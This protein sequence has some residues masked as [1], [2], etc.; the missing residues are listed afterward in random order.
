MLQCLS[1][2]SIVTQHHATCDGP[3]GI[4][5]VQGKRNGPHPR[6][7][8]WQRATRLSRLPGPG[9]AGGWE[10]RP[11]DPPF[12]PPAL[13]VAFPASLRDGS[14]QTC[15]ERNSQP[16]VQAHAFPPAPGSELHSSPQTPSLTLT[17]RA[18]SPHFL[19]RCLGHIS[20]WRSPPWL[21]LCP[22]F[23]P[24]SRGGEPFSTDLS[25]RRSLGKQPT[26]STSGEPSGHSLHACY[27]VFKS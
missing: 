8:Q 1:P 24:Q 13:S 3:E 16:P 17:P 15:P 23:P 14:N 12:S 19:L 5:R 25:H 11:W 21:H 27:S 6:R 20:P 7:Q 26:H 2:A 22:L 9:R 4:S 10:P 18:P